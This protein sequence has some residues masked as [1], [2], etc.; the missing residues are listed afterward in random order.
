ME[1]AFIQTNLFSSLSL[2]KA[3][4]MRLTLNTEKSRCIYSL[5][6]FEWVLIIWSK[7]WI[8]PDYLVFWEIIFYLSS[9]SVFLKISCYFFFCIHL[10]IHLIFFDA[11]YSKGEHKVKSVT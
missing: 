9:T 1:N 2:C 10:H 3:L 5:S 7:L 4:I 6:V 8:S 11:A